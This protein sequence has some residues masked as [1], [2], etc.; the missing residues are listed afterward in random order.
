MK[1][2]VEYANTIEKQLFEMGKKFGNVEFR[3]AAKKVAVRIIKTYK[4]IEDC[5][6]NDEVCKLWTGMSASAYQSRHGIAF[7][8]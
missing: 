6:T 4:K 1:I 3:P 5:K 7:N 8:E 2:N